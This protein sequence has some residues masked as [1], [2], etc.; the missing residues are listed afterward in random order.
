ME[1]ENTTT[2]VTGQFANVVTQSYTDNATITSTDRLFKLGS[3]NVRLAFRGF[4]VNDAGGGIM[5]LGNGT[6]GLVTINGLDVTTYSSAAA[7]Q[8]GFA[9]EVGSILTLHNI[10][11]FKK[12]VGAGSYIGGAGRLNSHGFE[13]ALFS[14]YGSAPTTT[15]G[16]AW[17]DLTTPV[18]TAPSDGRY[19]QAR[20]LG[21]VYVSTPQTAGVLALRMSG[22]TEITEIAVAAATTGWKAVDS[23]WIDLADDVIPL[24]RLQISGTTSVVVNNA[25]MS[26]L[27]R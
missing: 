21:E 23:N 4:W 12:A 9:I 24:D 27:L 15:L 6:G 13:R 19:L 2:V 3:D 14:V 1:V 25:E 7:G 18:Q 11:R 5:A 16:T 10:S 20:L 17:A 8:T 26:L 22:H